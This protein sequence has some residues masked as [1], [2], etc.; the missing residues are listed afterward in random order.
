MGVFGAKIKP[1]GVAL[2]TIQAI[3]FAVI[4]LKGLPK[5]DLSHIAVPD[6]GV[7]L[8]GKRFA[9]N[10]RAV[11]ARGREDVHEEDPMFGLKE[12]FNWTDLKGREKWY[13]CTYHSF[14]YIHTHYIHK[15]DIL[16]LAR[17]ED[18][19]NVMLDHRRIEKG[20]KGSFQME[21]ATHDDIWN[22]YL[23]YRSTLGNKAGVSLESNQTV[24]SDNTDQK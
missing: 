12:R 21:T 19:G 16:L 9:C 14:T 18:L 7:G 13:I 8:R 4:Q 24:T 23:K 22:N 15:H 1:A 2:V 6:A 11:E 20:A 17:R 3:S 5:A 10:G